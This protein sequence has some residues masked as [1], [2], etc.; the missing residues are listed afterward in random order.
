MKDE[1]GREI[2]YLATELHFTLQGIMNDALSGISALGTVKAGRPI[3][4][5]NE[6]A[7]AWRLDEQLEAAT[8][9]ARMGG[10]DENQIREHVQNGYAACSRLM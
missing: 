5:A 3:P 8:R 7:K 4:S 1:A 9:L 10:M 2:E 6:V